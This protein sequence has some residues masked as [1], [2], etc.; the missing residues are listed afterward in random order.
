MA[1]GKSMQLSL[2]MQEVCNI[3]ARRKQ[4]GITMTWRKPQDLHFDFYFSLVDNKVKCMFTYT[5]ASIYLS[6]Y[7][8]LDSIREV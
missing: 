5:K 7:I 1:F 8:Y 6:K 3:Y 2:P 4:F